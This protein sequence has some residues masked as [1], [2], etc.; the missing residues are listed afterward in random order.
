MVR[1]GDYLRDEMGDFRRAEGGEALLQQV[2]WRLSIPRGSF[3]LLPGLGSQLH[4]LGRSKPSLRS[5]LASQYV[6]Q[7]LEDLPELAVEETVLKE[8]GSLDV[9]LRWQGETLTITVE[10][11]GM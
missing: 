10:T 5:A 1:E 3:P 6:A 9:K 7:A 4:T 2:L 11:G 8:D